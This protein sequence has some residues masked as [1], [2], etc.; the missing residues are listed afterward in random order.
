MR[1]KYS[2]NPATSFVSKEVTRFM[3]QH[4]YT[5]V[6]AF[7]NFFGNV[8]FFVLYTF[9]SFFVTKVRGNDNTDLLLTQR[10]TRAIILHKHPRTTTKYKK[11]TYGVKNFRTRAH[12]LRTWSFMH[13]IPASFQSKGTVAPNSL[14]RAPTLGWSL[15]PEN[16]RTSDGRLRR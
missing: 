12:R 6:L 5:S 3:S 13:G 8:F 16:T 11:T 4:K 10:E 1:W 7:V 14:R 9:S 15:R 2:G